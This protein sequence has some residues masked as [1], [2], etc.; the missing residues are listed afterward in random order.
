MRL[1]IT[2][3]THFART[4]DGAVWADGPT[5]Y[6]LWSRYLSVFE[7]VNVIARVDDVTRAADGW[8]RADGAGVSF[9]GVPNY[10]G[11]WQYL[12]RAGR[13]RDAARGAVLPDDAIILS[14][15]G[16]IANCIEPLL[17]GGRPFA[18]QVV[19]DPYDVFSPSSVKHPLRPFFRWWFPLKL[20]RQCRR[21][22]A[23]LYV[24]QQALQRR[25]PCPAHEVGVSDVDLPAT[26]IAD[27]PRP[28]DEAK[29]C[30]R[31]LFV[32][33]LAQLYKAPDVLVEAVGRCV[34]D[35][36]DLRLTLIGDGKHRAELA[37]R[38]EAL[39][40]SDRVEFLGQLPAGAAIRK[41]L[42]KADLFVLPSR[43]EG[44]PRAL[45]EAMARGLPCIGSQVGGFPELLESEDLV[46][47]NDV[48]ALTVKIREVV[49]D[50]ARMARMSE[51][52]LTKA[53]EYSDDLLRAKRE[54]F[55]RRLKQRTTD[56]LGVRNMGDRR[57][58][59]AAR[60]LEAA[61]G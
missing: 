18:V 52:N 14:V 36:L 55:W 28:L 7:Q 33:T 15:S 57:T 30:F 37:A 50:P 1:S 61:H 48:D 40:I 10:F 9:S 21:A 12:L 11:P 42:D 16:Q 44:L 49:A 53:R 32:G 17:A 22:D 34:Q 19:A 25:Y 4:P 54:A 45:V 2:S 47:A 23:A 20:R 43:Q 27:A 46:V 6:P 29:R 24:T 41:E 3:E 51:R 39:R 60:A 38:A 59:S 5:A 26:A 8:R 13:V 35:G 31:L 56:W 58:T